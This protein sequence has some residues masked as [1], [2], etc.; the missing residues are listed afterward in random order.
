MII[1]RIKKRI[2]G[3]MKN[4][5]ST[6]VKKELYKHVENLEKLAR[7]TRNKY[8]DLFVEL[9]RTILDDIFGTEE[10]KA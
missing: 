6:T 8:D 4:M 3:E 7:S 2:S 10:K 5:L 9:L 1:D